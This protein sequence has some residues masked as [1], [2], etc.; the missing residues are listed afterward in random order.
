MGLTGWLN[1]SSCEWAVRVATIEPTSP[2][3]HAHVPM[4]PMLTSPGPHV[5]LVWQGYQCVCELGAELL[6]AY[7]RYTDILALQSSTSLPALLFSPLL[8][9]L[10]HRVFG[11]S[12]TVWQLDALLPPDKGP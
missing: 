11:S 3:P 9:S 1:E 2:G 8:L 5:V 4:T 10:P 6:P 7:S 12:P